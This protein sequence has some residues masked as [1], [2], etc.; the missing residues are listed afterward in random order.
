MSRVVDCDRAI[1]Q[2]RM[3]KA[4]QFADAATVVRDLAEES[5][6]VADAFSVTGGDRIRGSSFEARSSA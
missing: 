1:R 6:D 5:G 3:A 2:G 4:Q